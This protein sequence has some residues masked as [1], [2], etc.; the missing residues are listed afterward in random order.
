MTVCCAVWKGHFNGVKFVIVPLQAVCFSYRN[1]KL[2]CLQGDGLLVFVSQVRQEDDDDDDGGGQHK[3][4]LKPIET[5]HFTLS[6]LSCST[7]AM[8]IR[9]CYRGGGGGGGLEATC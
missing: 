6:P 1:M 9:S 4:D 3:G 2:R 5:K 8:Q 7:M